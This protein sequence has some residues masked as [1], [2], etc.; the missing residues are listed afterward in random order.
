[1]SFASGPA[2]LPPVVV[3]ALQS[4]IG[5][6]RDSGQSLLALPFTSKEFGRILDE[7][8]QALSALLGVPPGYAVLFLQGGAFAH[9]A[10]LA[11]NLAGEGASADYVE[12]GLWSRRAMAEACPWVGVR[13]AA[14]GSGHELPSPETWR[15]SPAAAYCHYTSNETAD[16]LQYHAVPDTGAVPLVADMSADF[17]TRPLPLERFGLVYASAQKNLGGA[18]LTVVI[19]REDL[20]GRTRPGTPAPFDYTR[21]AR[22]RSRV[23]TPPTFAIAVAA[24]MMAWLIAE[25]GLTAAAERARRKSARLYAVIDAGDFYRAPVAR[26]DRSHV[27]VR[28]HVPTTQLEDMFLAEAEAEGLLY[29]AGHPSVGGL[30]ASLYNGVPEEAAEALAGFMT[31]F[32]RRRG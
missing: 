19:V 28:F 1:M 25:G 29:L 12:T 18:G 17:C 7:A 8:E 6:W 20:L 23:S 15:V 4:E 26:A 14:L 24:K 22:E 21:Q 10:L 13:C 11:M 27:S 31:D 3:E 2:T 16:G 32:A 9:F 5:H 30:R